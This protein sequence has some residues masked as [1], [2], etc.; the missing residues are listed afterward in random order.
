MASDS[1]S[2]SGVPRR[3]IPLYVQVLIGVL[4]GATLG[5]VFGK[6]A[7]LFG[8]TNKDLGDLGILVIDLLK[9]LAAP[10]ILF[11]ILD[12][13]AR[14]HITARHG[15][16]L[17]LICLVNVSVAMGIGLAIMNALQPG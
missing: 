3:K 11:A 5:E 7:Y 8:L 10:L 13:F 16:R 2:A 9:A 17:I 4:V 14:T 6:R 1:P 15:G 12:S